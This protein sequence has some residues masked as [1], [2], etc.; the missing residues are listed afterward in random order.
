MADDRIKPIKPIQPLDGGSARSKPRAPTTKK[1][2]AAEGKLPKASL[3]DAPEDP[4][5]KPEIIITPPE[6]MLPGDP[7]YEAAYLDALEQSLRQPL[8]GAPPMSEG[9]IARSLEAQRQRFAQPDDQAVSGPSPEVDTSQE[10][11]A[12]SQE[13]EADEP[14]PSDAQSLQAERPPSDDSTAAPAADQARGADLPDEEPGEEGPARLEAEEPPTN[15]AA[16]LAASTELAGDE[17]PGPADEPTTSPPVTAADEDAPGAAQVPLAD[18]PTPANTQEM[19]EDDL[20]DGYSGQ[21]GQ[22]DPIEPLDLPDPALPSAAGDD[23][24]ALGSDRQSWQPP[25]R[26]QPDRQDPLGEPGAALREPERD[27]DEVQPRARG[28]GDRTDE[29]IELLGRIAE[30]IDDLKVSFMEMKESGF[31]A[32]AL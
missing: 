12:A 24:V 20:P 1:G 28:D 15:A 29:V 6:P 26:Q 32:T 19:P 8:P 22:F 31:V 21:I 9:A 30:G 17:L 13:A 16:P 18:A 5:V 27:A 3:P 10:Q 25:D 7:G 11:Q 4:A 2:P 14:A 23:E